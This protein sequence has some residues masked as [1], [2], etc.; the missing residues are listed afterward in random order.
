MNITILND[1]LDYVR[2]KVSPA[3]PRAAA[4]LGSGWSDVVE[5]FEA[6]LTLSYSDIPG[7]GASQVA[8]HGGRLV[9]A[10]CGDTSLLIFQGRRHWY[11][12]LGWEPIAMPVYIA[13]QLGATDIL[14]TNA[15]GG[16]RA[17]MA[18]GQLMIIDDHINAM[19]VNPL[20]GPHI[21][22]WG[23]R[24]PDMSRVYDPTGRD[25][26]RDTATD[27]GQEI[28]SGV[29]LAAHGPSYETPAEIVAYQKLGADAV[30]MSTVPEAILANA[31]GMRVAGISCITNLAAGVSDTPLSHDE[32][33]EE[34][35]RSQPRMQALLPEYFKRLLANVHATS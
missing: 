21:D 23:P 8:G 13:S 33:I 10:S 25:L 34:T 29:Y 2:S 3:K 9:L 32:V 28:H 20:I 35:A 26:L 27:L 14:L 16:I 15:A 30:G 11:E 19:G 4:V 24:F 6:Q 12:G 17:D 1:A 5:A 7:F 31:A 22:A 18:P